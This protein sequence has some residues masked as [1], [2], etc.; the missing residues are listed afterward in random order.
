MYLK[1][2][3]VE[4]R[5]YL[6]TYLLIYLNISPH[7]SILDVYKNKSIRYSSMF[8]QINPTNF[9][10]HVCIFIVKKKKAFIWQDYLGLLHDVI[11]VV[12]RDTQTHGKW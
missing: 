10:I 3:I 1:I 6:E 8:K 9:Q 2:N 5:L 12:N 11:W 7:T 4:Y